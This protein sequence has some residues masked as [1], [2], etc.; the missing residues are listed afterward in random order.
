MNKH[1]FMKH[2]LCLF[3]TD[4]FRCRSVALQEKLDST[5]HTV[6]NSNFP[7]DQLLFTF[8]QKLSCQILFKNIKSILLTVL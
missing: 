1:F 5:C 3:T 6:V 7:K 4:T 8:F 2:C